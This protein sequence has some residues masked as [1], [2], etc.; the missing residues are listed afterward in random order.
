MVTLWKVFVQISFSKIN[1]WN[2]LTLKYA[3][4]GDSAHWVWIW[5]LYSFNLHQNF[6][7]F[8]GESWH[9]SSFSNIVA[10]LKGHKW[11][12]IFYA[13]LHNKK[14]GPK[15]YYQIK[16]ET[17][18]SDL[19]PKRNSESFDELWQNGGCFSKFVKFHDPCLF[20]FNAT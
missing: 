16:K 15:S 20:H 17:D 3:G 5:G 1:G 13:S 7:I 8:F 12:S 14:N 10:N 4:G 2:L 19:S 6:S 18:L 9:Q 11:A